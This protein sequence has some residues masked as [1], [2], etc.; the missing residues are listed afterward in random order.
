MA[1]A[2]A[3]PRNRRLPNSERKVGWLRRW[4]KGLTIRQRI[5]AVNIFA[6]A[7]LFG[8]IFY[9]DSFRTRLTQA[10]IEQAQ[11]EAVMIAHMMAAIPPAASARPVAG[12]TAHTSGSTAPP[13]AAA[14]AA[15]ARA[16]ATTIAACPPRA[17]ARAS[18]PGF[19]G[20]AVHV[21]GIA[22][23]SSP[24]AASA[25]AYGAAASASRVITAY[26]ISLLYSTPGAPCSATVR[27]HF[28]PHAR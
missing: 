18:S 24:S 13:R 1:S 20:G 21:T 16:L 3:S 5:L 12:P 2:I 9:L 4:S 26:A 25:A 23:P 19:S 14:S 15:A 27:C 11:S 28:M 7:I 17:I 6:I 8:S 10:R 22:T